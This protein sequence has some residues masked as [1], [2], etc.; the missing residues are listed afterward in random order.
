M[1]INIRKADIKDLDIISHIEN[2]C[3][4]PNEAASYNSILDRINTFSDSFLLA[5]YKDEIIG[6]IN[7]AVVSEKYISDDM[8]SNINAH[9]SD[10][11]YQAI[12]GLDVLP[13]YRNKGVA[14]KLLEQFIDNAYKDNKK[15]VI[16]TCKEHLLHYYESF[17]FKNLGISE[18]VHGGAVWYDCILEF[19]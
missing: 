1:E 7:G 8:F 15:A 2:I 14:K 10:N 18:S 13:E 17:G 5:I 6:F 11:N 19:N 4:P 3:F 16:L 9:D 12:F